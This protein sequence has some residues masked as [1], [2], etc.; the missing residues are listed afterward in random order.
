MEEDVKLKDDVIYTMKYYEDAAVIMMT[1]LIK[2]TS[3]TRI[4]L[5]YIVIFLYLKFCIF[6]H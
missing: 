6:H 2:C 3:I 1:L 5:L 4:L